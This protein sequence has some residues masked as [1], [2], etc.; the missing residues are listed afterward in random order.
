M[1]SVVT[2]ILLIED[3]PGD[4]E[5]IMDILVDASMDQRFDIVHVERLSDG[6]N[7][8]GTNRSIWFFWILSLPDSHG[9]DTVVRMNRELPDLPVMVLTGLNDE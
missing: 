1:N 3:N 6:L 7:D 4:A 2:K 5:L 9:I 8:C